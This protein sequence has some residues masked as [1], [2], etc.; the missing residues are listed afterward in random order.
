[1]GHFQVTSKK[2]A[3]TAVAAVSL[4]HSAHAN[5]GDT[6]AASCQR[7]G[8][9]GYVDRQNRFITWA[10]NG[11]LIAEQFRKNQCVCIIY[12]RQD[13][14][15]FSD[16]EVEW[17]LSNNALPFHS[18]REYPDV[19]GRSWNTNDNKIYARLVV[20]DQVPVM[21]VAYAS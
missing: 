1:M 17:F 2:I 13:R 10:I 5:L 18:W 15:P 9:R 7:Y 12:V 16:H 14:K 20:M 11:Y 6:Y 19:G 8:G 3:I 4:L 21:R